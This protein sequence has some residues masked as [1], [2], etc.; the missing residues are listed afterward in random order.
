MGKK[1]G[2]GRNANRNKCS[3]GH[4]R[5]HGQ[6]MGKTQNHRNRIEQWLAVGSWQLV[7]VGGW[8]LEVGGPWGLSLR[9]ALNK[10]K[11]GLLRTALEGIRGDMGLLTSAGVGCKAHKQA[12]LR[13]LRPRSQAHGPIGRRLQMA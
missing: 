1:R 10:K 11:M 2:R 4:S 3:R 9:A 6:D 7:A 13:L 5:L 8:R 12:M